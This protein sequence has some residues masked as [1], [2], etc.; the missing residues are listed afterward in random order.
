[1]QIGPTPTNGQRWAGHLAVGALAS[2]A[3]AQYAKGP[4]L[5]ITAFV[6][7]VIAHEYFDAPASQIIAAVAA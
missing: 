1:M 6:V 7:G 4:A 2:A 3:T 5:P